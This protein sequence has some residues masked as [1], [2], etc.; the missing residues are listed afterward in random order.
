MKRTTKD[1]REKMRQYHSHSAEQYRVEVER[2]RALGWRSDEQTARLLVK[3]RAAQRAVSQVGDLIARALTPT[4]A[5]KYR[6]QLK[7]AQRELNAIERKLGLV[8]DPNAGAIE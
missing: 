1:R 8:Y 2:L 6:S 3:H 4:D 5:A 7:A